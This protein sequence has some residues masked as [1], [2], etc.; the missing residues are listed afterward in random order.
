MRKRWRLVFVGF[1]AA[2]LAGVAVAQQVMTESGAISGVSEN[3]LS[4]YKGVPS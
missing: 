3:E 1:V 2:Q 4:V